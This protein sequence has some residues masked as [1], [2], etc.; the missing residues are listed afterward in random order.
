MAKE[1]QNYLALVSAT[2]WIATKAAL[3]PNE[4]MKFQRQMV[5]NIKTA[6]ENEEIHQVMA[7][8]PLFSLFD[9]AQLYDSLC[10]SLPSEQKQ[11]W[12]QLSNILES[13]LPLLLGTEGEQIVKE[14]RAKAS[15]LVLSKEKAAQV[16]WKT[17]FDTEPLKNLLPGNCIEECD[18]HA[19]FAI[20]PIA[21]CR[22]IDV[23]SSL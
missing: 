20:R 8:L 1:N 16:G 11:F 3:P 22:N 15:E 18:I 23:G 2:A 14:A 9:G 7:Y 5:E 4:L 19:S 12:N 17:Y 13:Q 21:F 6:L 10:N